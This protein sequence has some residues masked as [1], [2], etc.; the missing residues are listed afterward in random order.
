VDKIP[1]TLTSRIG[2]CPMG[3][4][5]QLKT[6]AA[7]A[8]LSAALAGCAGNLWAPGPNAQGTFDAAS[9]ACRIVASGDRTSVYAKGSPGF[10]AGATAGAAIGDAMRQVDDYNNCMMAKGW[11]VTGKNDKATIDAQKGEAASI[12][13]D[14]QQCTASARRNPKYAVIVPYLADET[15]RH[16]SLSQKANQH[17]ATAEEVAALSGFADE[18]SRC[19]DV[20]LDA[21]ARLDPRAATRARD[22]RTAVNNLQLLVVEKK[23]NWGDYSQAA[24]AVADAAQSG[25]PMPPA[26]AVSAN[27]PH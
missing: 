4:A 13:T 22:F 20:H 12:K 9:A 19:L 24:E 2:N 17:F 6:C 16:F 27:A 11:V 5:M 3:E 14:M 7:I 21:I 1:A 8:A 26:P 10:V 23:L 25:R 15:T 18:A